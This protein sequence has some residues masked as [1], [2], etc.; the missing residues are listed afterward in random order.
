VVEWLSLPA[1]QRPDFVCLY[2]EQPDLQGH[3]FGPESQEVTDAIAAADAT[4]GDI[5]AGL[6]QVRRET[7]SF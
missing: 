7:C 4:L 1:E 3:I 5:L 6:T 2:F